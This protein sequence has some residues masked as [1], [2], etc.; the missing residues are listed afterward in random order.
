MGLVKS[1]LDNLESDY[2]AGF[3]GGRRL[4]ENLFIVI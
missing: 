3:S 2:Q 4:E 1:K